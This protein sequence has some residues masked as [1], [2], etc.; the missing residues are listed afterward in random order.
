MF[1]K[2]EYVARDDSVDARFIEKRLHAKGIDFRDRHLLTAPVDFAGEHA[3]V[4]EEQ[5][6]LGL[7][8]QRAM[9][10]RQ[11]KMNKLKLKGHLFDERYP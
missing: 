2:K 11:F 5:T 8:A 10:L 1:L 4:R 3:Q 9:E 6:K 7:E